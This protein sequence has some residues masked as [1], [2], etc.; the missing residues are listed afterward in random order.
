MFAKNGAF[1]FLAGLGLCLVASTASA[2]WDLDS[3]NSSLSFIT[4]KNSGVAEVHSFAS[5]VGYVGDNGHVEIG[6]DL[7][8][9]DTAI[10][11]RD[12]RM[13]EFLFE[14][15]T[16]PSANV[17]A[18]ID[19][20]LIAALQPGTVMTTDVA[21]QLS[22]HGKDVQ[23]SVPVLAMVE[24][25]GTLRVISAEPALLSAFQFDLVDGINKLRELAGL[26]TISTAVPV[27][28]SL[29]FKPAQPAS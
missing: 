7:G 13:R 10:E 15:E 23:L 6:I 9:V 17:T 5:L 26:D 2:Q 29:V 24:S 25:D 3:D 21:M 22:L 8:S 19:P 18:D 16:Y 1:N 20:A 28:F 14:T 12:E 27:T 11:I 4:T